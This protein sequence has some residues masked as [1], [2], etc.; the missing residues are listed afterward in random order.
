M[1]SGAMEEGEVDETDGGSVSSKRAK[2]DGKGKSPQGGSEKRYGPPPD[3]YVCNA[4]HATGHWLEQCPRFNDYRKGA[5]PPGY[6]CVKCNQAGH[7]V[8]YCSSAPKGGWKEHSAADGR[9]QES[10]AL[11]VLPEAREIGDEIA[12]ALE[13]DLPEVVTLLHRC[14]QALGEAVSR[15]LLVQTWQVEASG[16]LLTTDG[17]NRKRTPGGTFFWLVKQK[18]SADD[19]ARIFA[20]RS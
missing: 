18:A 3:G 20:I 1:T 17:T 7:W 10:E 16:G 6:V 19:R 9:S 2:H 14:V 5:P 11:I 4:C 13:E 8:H 12:E 15:Q